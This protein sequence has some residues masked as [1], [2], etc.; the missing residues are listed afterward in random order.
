M[1]QQQ[2]MIQQ[3]RMILQH[4]ER[5]NI[6]P[7][8]HRHAVFA[9]VCLVI[10]LFMSVESASG[11]ETDDVQPNQ[12]LFLQAEKLIGNATPNG[13]NSSGTLC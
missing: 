5:T 6:H 11:Q 9:I 2:I 12:P 7:I 3:S 10:A 8:A 13:E 1:I 4:R